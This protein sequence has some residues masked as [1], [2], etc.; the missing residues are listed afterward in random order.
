M[1]R[2]LLPGAMSL[3]A[4][5]VPT[6]KRVTAGVVESGRQFLQEGPAQQDA[7]SSSGGGRG[8]GARSRHRAAAPAADGPAAGLRNRRAGEIELSDTTHASA[9]RKDD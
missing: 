7:G 2:G 3:S 1:Q 8:G 5:F 4:K 6:L 9:G